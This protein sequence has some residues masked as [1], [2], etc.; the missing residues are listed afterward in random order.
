MAGVPGFLARAWYRRDPWLWLLRPVEAIYRLVMLLRRLLYRWGILA[1]YQ[2][3][4]PVV[5]VGNITTGGTGKT[6]VVIALVEALGALGVQTGVVSRGYGALS[7]AL[8]HV[9]DG[10]SSPADCGDEPLLIYRRTGV[11]CVVSPS[12]VA[13]TRTLLARFPVDLVISD[14][15]LQ[16]LAL[17]RSLE[18]ALLDGEL[19][20]GNGFCLPAGPLREPRRRLDSVDF[21]LV[22]G[23]RQ[24]ADRVNYLPDCL[25][26]LYD[27]RKVAA[28]SSELGSDVYAL[29][30]IAWPEHF[31]AMLR[32]LGFD[33]RL[34]R[35]DDHHRYRPTDLHGLDDKPLIMTEKDAVKCSPFAGPN[36]WCLRIRANIPGAVVDAAAALAQDRETS[37]KHVL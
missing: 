33:P 36:A 30:G 4:R 23:R 20:T 19:L 14:D 7:T 15:G 8:P 18:I 22:R 16:H 28:T 11:P 24:G 6:P 9:V 29:A 21:T 26:N 13:A 10:S 31:V 27:G 2:P 25:Y 34:R 3:S 12:R 35:F 1:I 17:G 5:V 37:K 32:E